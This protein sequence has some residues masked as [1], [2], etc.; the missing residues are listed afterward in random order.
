MPCFGGGKQGPARACAACDAVAFVFHCIQTSNRVATPPK[1]PFPLCPLSAPRPAP[2]FTCV[3]SPPQSAAIRIKAHRQIAEE[4]VQAQAGG[5]GR[6]CARAAAAASLL[7]M[8]P[9]T[10]WRAA[11]QLRLVHTL[12]A[13]L[14]LVGWAAPAS[15]QQLTP[16][17]G[18]GR[19]PQGGVD[20]Y[21]S[22]VMDH[23]VEV[24]DANYRFEA[25]HEIWLHLPD[26]FPRPSA[27]PGLPWPNFWVERL[28]A[29]LSR[30]EGHGSSRLG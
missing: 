24:D 17:Q 27:P 9:C 21:M 10:C 20:V 5:R 26:A 14:L 28:A 25:S 8:G 18:R 3:L 11:S 12:L 2:V 30:V 6:R 22:A 29:C 19:P 7:A 1:V 13:A 15:A 16:F 4:S 23:L